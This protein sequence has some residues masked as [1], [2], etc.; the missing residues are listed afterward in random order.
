MRGFIPPLRTRI[1]GAW[2]ST[3]YVFMAWC[4]VKLK[5]RDIFTFTGENEVV[6]VTN[7]VT[8]TTTTRTGVESKITLV[9]NHHIIIVNL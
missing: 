3:G 7:H 6:L 9:R 1:H 5:H 2:L 4:I 8:T